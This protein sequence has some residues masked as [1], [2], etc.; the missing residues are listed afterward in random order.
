MGSRTGKSASDDK[1]WRVTASIKD[2]DLEKAVKYRAIDDDMKI[3]DIVVEA[4][5]LYL[6]TAPHK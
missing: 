5:R 3:E 2:K 4:L 1:V 6:K